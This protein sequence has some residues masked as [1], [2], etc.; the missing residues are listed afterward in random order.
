MTLTQLRT[1]LAIAETGS[2]HAAADR[3]FITQSAVSASLTSLQKSL[4]LRL[5]ERDGRG[6]RL[7]DA[8]KVY[9]HYVRGVL[10]LLDEGRNAASAESDPER[11]ELRI[12]A[13]TTAGERILPWI[14]AD[15]RAQHPRM[16]ISMEV[17]NRDRV[18]RLLE[19]HEVDLVLGGRPDYEREVT[20][21]AV[22]PHEL[23]VVAPPEA[24]PTEQGTPTWLRRATWLLREP[25]SG[26][27]AVTETFLAGLDL[28]AAPRTLTMGSNTAMRESVAAGLGIT[29]ISRDAVARELADG[30]LVEVPVPGAPLARDWHLVANPGRLPATAAMLTAHILGTG[31][32]HAP[33]QPEPPGDEH[34]PGA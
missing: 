3:L 8:G 30:R 27:R 33:A 26:T 6:V 7:T 2:V 20:V 9:A 32:F 23:I 16:G 5:L 10:G 25:E 11:G 18:R 22:R 24:P 15:F 29:L 31:N 4:G 1:F 14:L 12:A 34:P 13:V 19:R 21:L 28:G 17:G